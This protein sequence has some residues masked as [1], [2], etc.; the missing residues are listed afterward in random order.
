MSLN[1]SLFPVLEQLGLYE[2][3]Q[4]ISLP[5]GNTFD[6]YDSDLSLLY[7]LNTNISHV[8]ACRQEHYSYQA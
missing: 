8:Y 5:A 3:L 6:I 7:A 4:K 1:A 2:E